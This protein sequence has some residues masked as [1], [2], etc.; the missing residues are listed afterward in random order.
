VRGAREVKM[1]GAKMSKH[2]QKDKPCIQ[3]ESF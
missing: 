1:K 2:N 3:W